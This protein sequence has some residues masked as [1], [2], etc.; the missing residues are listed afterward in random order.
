MV[1]FQANASS[2][3]ETKMTGDELERQCYIGAIVRLLGKADLEA[4]ELIWIAARNLTATPSV[5][6]EA[7]KGTKH[8]T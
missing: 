2:T 5:N 8:E 7:K 1:S 3:P 6:A 4:L